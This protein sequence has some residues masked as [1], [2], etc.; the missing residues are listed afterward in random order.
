MLRID[1]TDVERSKGRYV[2]AIKN[3][4]KWL[5]ISY[6]LE[7][8]QSNRVSKYEEA[9]EQ[10][11][12]AGRLYPCYETTEELEFKRKMQLGQGKPPVYDRA[13]LKLTEKDIYEFEAAG[14]TPHYRFKLND[15]IVTWADG[16]RGVIELNPATMSDPILVRENG[17]FTYMLPS[18]VDDIEFNVTHVIRG[19]D[20]I[21]NT[22][23]QIQIFE[24]LGGVVPK[25]AH[26]ALIKTKDGNLS[27]RD[28]GGAVADLK[29]LGIQPMAVNSFLAKIGTSDNVELKDNLEQLIE[30]FSI[31]KF[32]KSPTM[33]SFDDISRLNTKALHDSNYDDVKS[34]LPDDITQE[35]WDNVKANIES[36]DDVETWWKICHDEIKPEFENEHDE[37]FVKETADVFPD[38]EVTEDTWN[39]WLTAIKLGTDR[40]GKTLFMPL[41][42]ALTGMNHG[43]E[44]KNLLPLIGRE[45][46]LKRLNS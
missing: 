15:S 20:H 3:D 45:E 22:A 44:I 37:A 6:D 30:E 1:D 19:E 13:S 25:F 35:F 9:I 11:K 10:L 34:K 31:G 39:I 46:I 18:T 27:K 12:Q 33:Y 29:E 42:Q 7:A 5:G 2:D 17:A 24:A 26:N 8:K 14:R 43:P 28:G 36:L 23:V 41:R 32:G 4:L 40:K 21:S 38:G 16:V